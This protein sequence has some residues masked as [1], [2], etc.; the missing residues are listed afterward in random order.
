MN[1]EAAARTWVEAWL[2]S[3]PTRDPEPVASLYADDGIFLSHAFRAPLVGPAGAREYISWAT[4]DQT[5]VECAFAEPIVSGDRAAVEWWAVIRS[6]DGT[7]ETVA[8]T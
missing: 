5:A 1:T 8:G 6:R 3:W 4:E 2:R 7:E